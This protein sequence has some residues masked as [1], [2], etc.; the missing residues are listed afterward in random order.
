MPFLRSLVAVLVLGGGITAMADGQVEPCDYPDSA[1]VAAAWRPGNEA[2]PARLAGIKTPDGEPALEFSCDMDRLNERAYWDRSVRLDLSRYSRFS[3]WMRV[4]GD[5]SAIASCTLYFNAGTGWYGQGFGVPDEGWRK[6]TLHRSGFLSE[7]APQGWGEVRGIR[8]SFWKGAGRKA[9]VLLGPISADTAR[10]PVVR[11]V[12]G[13]SEAE[14]WTDRTT[15]LLRAAGIDAGAVDSTDVERGALANKKLVIYPNNGRVTEAEAAALRDFVAGGGKILACFSLPPALAEV[16]GLSDARYVRQERPDQFASMRFV[17]KLPPG[18]PR[19]VRQASWNVMDV[20]PAARNARV[21]A[22]WHDGSGK[23]TGIPAVVVSDAGAYISHVLLEDD[24]HAKLRMLRGLLGSMDPGLWPEVAQASLKAVAVGSSWATF[25]ESVLGIRQA[26]LAAGRLPRVQAK[27]STAERQL[28]KARAASEAARYHAVLEPADAARRALLE[29]FALSQPA[30]HGEFRAVWCHSAYGVDGMTW[31]EAV[32]NLKRCGF[33]A[34]VP[35]MLWGGL[36]D[37]ASD[38]LPVSDRCKREGDQIEACLKAC[39]KHGIEVH[40]WKVNWNLANAP[41]DFV[42]R[43]R[44]EG[45]LQRNDAGQEVRWL[46]PSHPANFEL[47]RDTMLEVA[48]KYAV[49]GIHFDYIRYPDSSTCYCDGCRQRFEAY[50]AGRGGDAR[51]VRQWPADVLR[52]GPLNAEYREFRRQNITRVVEAVAREARRIRPGIKVSAAV[53]PNWPA[54]RDEIGQDWGE[55]V[56]RG[57]LDFVCPMDYTASNRGFRTLVQV[58]REEVAGR[59]PLYPGIGA[60]APGLDPAQVLEQIAILR[61]E[62]APGF[63]IFNYDRR[64]AHEHLPLL[65]QGATKE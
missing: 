20:R 54:C 12:A 63:I 25:E 22:W 61:E 41:D 37:Y 45:R 23:T 6:V 38:L 50:L 56:R 49:D 30:R 44:A 18:M 27:L 16:L 34:V 32:A 14:T 51:S 43:L 2:A 60:S 53:F 35:N 36:A 3:F 64:T 29:A 58:Q 15:D 13:G 10:V 39:R 21:L 48:R 17:G 47:E 46:C 11:N 7:D 65:R 59:I 24:R 31:D 57:Y 9:R 52:G 4:E 55:W 40:V 5:A 62:G 42:A 8:V 26:A 28:A 33:T 19:Q 1:A